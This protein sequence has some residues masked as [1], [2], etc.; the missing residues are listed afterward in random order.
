MSA[1]ARRAQMAET[2]SILWSTFWPIHPKHVTNASK[3]ESTIRTKWRLWLRCWFKN[4]MEMVLRAAGKPAAY[5]V[6]VVLIMAEILM[7]K[8]EF[9]VVAFFK[10]W[11]RAVSD[12]LSFF[13][14]SFGLPERNTDNSTVKHTEYT[15]VACIMNKTVFSRAQI[16][17]VFVAQELNGSRIAASSLC[18]WKRFSH[19]VRHIISLLL[20]S[21]S[22]HFQSTTTRSTTWT[23]R[24]SPR[25]R[26]TPSTA[27]RSRTSLRE[28]HK[29][30]QHLSH[31]CLVS[32]IPT[33][34]DWL[35]KRACRGGFGHINRRSDPHG[36]VDHVTSVKSEC[37][38]T[39]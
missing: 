6:F 10:A 38:C 30:A 15:P 26:C 28:W 17:H 1:T 3:S 13:A 23:A 14:C 35:L 22:S 12:F 27:S 9:M 39:C 5:F 31:S 32:V 16:T 11:Q 33:A 34:G 25:R 8:L 18:A 36:G 29:P 20:P 2:I 37:P 4:K 7:A 21:T 24:P 19:L